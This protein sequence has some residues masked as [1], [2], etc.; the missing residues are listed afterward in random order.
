VSGPGR[1]GPLAA[2]GLWSGLSEVPRHLGRRR[3][4]EPLRGGEAGSARIEAVFVR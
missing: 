4:M 1:L 2:G 3:F